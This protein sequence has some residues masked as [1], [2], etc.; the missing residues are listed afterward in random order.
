[1]DGAGLQLWLC[2]KKLPLSHGGDRADNHRLELAGPPLKETRSSSQSSLWESRMDPRDG[3]EL[4]ASL[5]PHPDREMEA[6]RRKCTGSGG[7]AGF[8]V[9]MSLEV[10]P[11]AWR[12]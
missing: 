4:P 2:V 1:M 6:G 5:S 12:L 9:Q 11:P 3:P 10:T 8:Q 7:S